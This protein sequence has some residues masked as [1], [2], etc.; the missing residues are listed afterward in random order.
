MKEEILNN[1]EKYSKDKRQLEYEKEILDLLEKKPSLIRYIHPAIIFKNG[2]KIL[3]MVGDNKRYIKY[4]PTSVIKKNQTLI[5][6]FCKYNPV[7]FSYID[8]KIQMKNISDVID[9]VKKYPLNYDYLDERIKNDSKE[10]FKYCINKLYKVKDSFLVDTY[11]KYSFENNSLLHDINAVM[12]NKDL[13]SILGDSTKRIIKSQKLMKDIEDLSNNKYRFKIF[14]D[15]LRLYQNGEYIELHI[16]KIIKMVSKDYYFFRKNGNIISLNKDLYVSLFKDSLSIN[17]IKKLYYI[18]SNDLIH[19]NSREEFYSFTNLRNDYLYDMKTDSIRDIKNTIYEYNYAMSYEEI[20]SLINKYSS[21]IDYL[22]S[23]YKK[24][25]YNIDEIE[26]YETLLIFR[27]ILKIS[28]CNNISKLK[29][30]LE[31]AYINHKEIKSYDIRINIENR[32]KR[33]YHKEYERIINK[34]IKYSSEEKILYEDLVSKNKQLAYYLGKYV[35][36]KIV[37]INDF[38]NIL[39][40]KDIDDD[41]LFKKYDY[42]SNEYF[43]LDKNEYYLRVGN[44]ANKIVDIDTKSYYLPGKR[45]NK[46]IIE[47]SNILGIICFNEKIDEKVVRRAIE[48]NVPIEIINIKNMSKNINELRNNMLNK[49]LHYI[50]KDV[51]YIEDNR[52]DKYTP[53]DCIELFFNISNNM[54]IS[55]S[56]SKDLFTKNIRNIISKIDKINDNYIQISQMLIVLRKSIESIDN[57]YDKKIVYRDL[58]KLYR[59]YNL[60]NKESNNYEEILLLLDSNKVNDIILFN[61]YNKNQI[62]YSDV[63]DIIDFKKIEEYLKILE[64]NYYR[65]DIERI[66]RISIFSNILAG[67]IDRELI[68]LCL[69]TSVFSD[70][71]RLTDVRFGDYSASI[72]RSIFKNKIKK[73]DID[74]VC[75]AIDSQDSVEDTEKLKNKYK[76]KN[77]DKFMKVSTILK[78]ALYLDDY[79][80]KKDLINKEATRMLKIKDIVI[81]NINNYNI[82]LL[83]RKNIISKNYYLNLLNIGYKYEDIIE[84][85]KK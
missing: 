42:V 23:K 15:L 61:K 38:F 29:D 32:I 8:K 67:L 76:L 77:I 27:E 63:V 84:I 17:E 49:I 25:K 19:V 34:R 79:K 81:N 80:Y 2:E 43:I 60:Y 24:Y 52:I 41:N 39:V 14:I 7:L 58:D 64:D 85:C 6:G 33:I 69:L 53:I 10:L 47:D 21:S 37:D 59:K 36:I 78:D 70:I 46:L 44:V 11:Y 65:G 73:E 1:L 12:F 18:L 54:V 74:I 83:I 57:T 45:Y 28:N 5:F 66:I 50:D 82:E 31:D 30:L 51:L 13:V 3:N 68:N 71:G 20:N 75:A 26:E 55:N 16:N 40:R 62:E 4:I 56:I 9:I 48:L 22:V 35:N 72:F